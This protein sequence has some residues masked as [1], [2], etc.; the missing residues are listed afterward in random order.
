M[1]FRSEDHM[2]EEI[3]GE[4]DDAPKA[5]LEELLEYGE[6]TAGGLMNTEYV[7]VHADAT[8]ADAIEAVRSQPDLTD[9][10]TTLFLTDLDGR[11]SGVLP[12]TRALLARPDTPLAVLSPEEPITAHVDDKAVRV[13]ELFDKYNLL[14]LPV[15]DEEGRMAG[16]V[17]AD[18]IITLLR[19]K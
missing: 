18:D 6:D 16:A 17:T 2:S 3:L 11:L 12:V 5:E 4:M 15:V 14:A 13:A 10:V 9:G 1:L 7:A 8:A 19:R